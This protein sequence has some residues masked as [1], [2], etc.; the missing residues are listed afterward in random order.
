MDFT[1]F[2]GQPSAPPVDEFTSWTFDKISTQ[3]L[4]A[5]ETYS[6]CKTTFDTDDPT[7]VTGTA[8]C[9]RIQWTDALSTNWADPNDAA[10]I[11]D[12]FDVEIAFEA[13]GSLAA[14]SPRP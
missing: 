6:A 13:S 9:R 1:A 11:G 5:F 12:P 10:T 8:S 4:Q 14:S 7:R 2:P 3:H